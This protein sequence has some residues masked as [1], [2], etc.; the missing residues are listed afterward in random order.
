[1]GTHRS[2]RIQKF[3][4]FRAIYA[5]HIRV[6]ESTQAATA[7]VR[8]CA[9]HSNA[10]Y[11]M[12]PIVPISTQLTAELGGSRLLTPAFT[13]KYEKMKTDMFEI[14]GVGAF[15]ARFA[16]CEIARK[17]CCAVSNEAGSPTEWVVN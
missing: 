7:L 6:C 9:V 10:K 14:N 12:N 11:A 5:L 17:S 8:R 15:M 3:N 1:M 4:P 16:C 13:R 2:G